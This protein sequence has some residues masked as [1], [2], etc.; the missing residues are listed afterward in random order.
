VALVYTE[1]DDTII[2]AVTVA[3]QL[4]CNPGGEVLGYPIEAPDSIPASFIGRLLSREEAE[5]LQCVEPRPP[6]V[7]ERR[8]RRDHTPRRYR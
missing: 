2:E 1:G 6:V 5:G 4:G 8:R 3:H 7:S